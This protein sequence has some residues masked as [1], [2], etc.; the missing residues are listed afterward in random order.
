MYLF[1]VS[2]AGL[3]QLSTGEYEKPRVDDLIEKYE[4]ILGGVQY[5]YSM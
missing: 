4:W 5:E 2:I 3:V 1:L